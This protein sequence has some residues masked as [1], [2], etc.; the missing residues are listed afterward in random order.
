MVDEE[1][2]YRFPGRP[3]EEV[4][5]VTRVRQD[6]ETG[7]EMYD[8]QHKAAPELEARWVPRHEVKAVPKEG[9]ALKLANMEVSS[10]S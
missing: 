5:L 2:L 7:E 3:V 9:D 10:Y 6:D 1:V 8:L 4:V